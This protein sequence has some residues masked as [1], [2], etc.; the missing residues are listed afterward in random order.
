[1]KKF[2]HWRMS[3]G[4]ADPYQIMVGGLVVDVVRK[5]IKNLNL[6]V[7]PPD[8]RVRAAVPVRVSDKAVRL[9]VN[10]KLGWITRQQVKLANREKPLAREFVSGET[11]YYQG[12]RYRLNVIYQNGPNRVELHSNA[13]IDLF[14]REGS[15]SSQREQVLQA[16]Y[17]ERLKEQIP[18][19]IEKW[20]GLMEVEVAHWGVKRMRTRWGSCNIKARRIWLN[21]ELAK[22]SVNCLEYI[23]VHEMAHLLERLHND[24]FKT[25]M[26]GFMPEWRL[27]R[28]ELK[29]A[30]LR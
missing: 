3:G 2:W 5:D 23:T 27:Y 4:S 16:W 15:S 21:L 1:M 13:R 24:R 11:H 25:L 7:C 28:E 10:S 9:F 12:R 17:R 20:E 30:P 26:D 29:R 6:R 22:R 19:I 8:G 18:L 14:V